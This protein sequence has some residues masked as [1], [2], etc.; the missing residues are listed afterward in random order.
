MTLSHCT[1]STTPRTDPCHCEQIVAAAAVDHFH[2]P[3]HATS[4]RQYAQQHGIPRSTLGHWLRQPDPEGVDPDTA[5]FFRSSSGVAWLRRLVLALFA[6]FLFRGAC[7]LRLLSLL[8][9]LTHLDRFVA[10]STGAL[11]ELSRTIAADLSLFADEERPRL[12]EGMKHRHIALVPDENF[13]GPH[14]C[15]VAAE[16]ASNFLFVEQYADRRDEATWTA[17]IEPSVAGLPVTVLLL[18]SD[19]AKGIIAC[20][21]HGLAAQHLP[22]LFH[23]QRDLCQPLMGPLER[24]KQSA[25]NRLQQAQDQLQ[26]CR[27][28]AEQA[29]SEPRGPGRP[30]D[31]DQH[32]SRWEAE[33]EQCTQ[34]AEGCQERQQQALDA[35]R[36]VADDFHPFDATTGAAVE[37]A[38]MQKRLGQ[39][40]RGLQRVA[41]QAELGSKAQEA[42]QR[43]QR[44][45]EALVV[46]MEWFW[47]VARVL[48]EELDLPDEVEQAVYAKLLPGLYWQQA[49]RRGRTAEQRQHRE[50]L[51]GRLLS[52]A[53][54]AG[55]VLSRLTRVEQEEVKRVARE[56][57]GLF[58][59]SSSCVEGRNGRLSLFHHGQTRLSDQRLKAL[60]V[61]HNYQSTRA[62]GTTAAERFFGKKPRDLF[63]W[64]LERLPDLPR[65]AAKRPNKATQTS[66]KAG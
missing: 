24:Q 47:G 42:L 28:E 12:A 9:R 40:I 63:N 26:A 22:E 4:Q 41:E 5:A 54:V 10:S 6:V 44:W 18:S 57:V 14:V 50:D 11:H 49:A 38:E 19:Q 62:D 13:H 64:L 45:V 27:E 59:R 25:A 39:R 32:I 15:L 66:A 21:D 2:D 43:G 37:E 53:W 52:E 56:V 55:G 1:D 29:R 3:D 36:G 58:A 33:V 23:G 35:V 17:A 30:K 7:G 60:T 51:A 20:A 48:V 34:E 65:P 16:P 8:L 61:I 46:A 31:Y